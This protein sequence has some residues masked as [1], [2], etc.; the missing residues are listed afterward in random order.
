MSRHPAPRWRPSQLDVQ[1]SDYDDPF[2]TPSTDLD[3]VRGMWWRFRAAGFDVPFERGTI[4]LWGDQ[5]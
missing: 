5:R 4:I 2:I 3:D 1:S